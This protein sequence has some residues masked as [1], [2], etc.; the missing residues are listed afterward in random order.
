MRSQFNDDKNTLE[1][2]YKCKVR[3]SDKYYAQYEPDFRTYITGGMPQYVQRKERLF[4]ISITQEELSRLEYDLSGVERWRLEATEYYAAMQYEKSKRL[5][6]EEKRARNPAAAKAYEKYVLLLN[7][8][9]DTN[10]KP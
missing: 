6:E 2:K 3:E 9:A 5:Q 1:Y 8:T 7:M 4:E 10:G